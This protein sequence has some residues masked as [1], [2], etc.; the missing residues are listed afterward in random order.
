MNH[1]WYTYFTQMQRYLEAQDKR[2]LELE[3]QLKSLSQE[4]TT[5][6]DKPPIRV[7]RLEYKF[8][9]LKV[10]SLYGTLNIGLNPNDLNNIDEFAV[11]NQPTTPPP[12]IFPSREKVVHDMIEQLMAELNAMIQDTE[13]QVGIS[14]EPTY[15]EF[16]RNDIL[17]QLEQRIIM[18]FNNSSPME[19]S[20]HQLE[21][22]TENVYEKVKSD[23]Q[24]AL[25]NFITHS[26][27]Q[28]GGIHP[29]GI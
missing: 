23:I 22:L 3:Q 20:P 19:R 24:T 25:L 17:R 8:D 26:K 13:T 15:H 29:N 6:K 18:Y 11:N 12:F 7:D 1:D 4:I 14:L 16:I 9:Q 28:T 5:L 27:G 21:N 2:I 10:E